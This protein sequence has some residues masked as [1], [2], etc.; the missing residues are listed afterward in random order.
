VWRGI[1]EQVPPEHGFSE[2]VVAVE[3]GL[4]R[5]AEKLGEGRFARG[6]RAHRGSLKVFF[7]AAAVLVLTTAPTR[8]GIIAAARVHER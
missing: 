7:R 6:G 4:K 3:P 5:E 1:T 8:T 2:G